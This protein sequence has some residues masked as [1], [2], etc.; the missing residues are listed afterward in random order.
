MASKISPEM[1]ELL[2]PQKTPPALLIPRWGVVTSTNPLRVQLAGDDEPLPITPKTLTGGLVLG[3]AV[4]CVLQGA[5]LIVVA[6][7]NGGDA[8]VTGTVTAST[9]TEAR[10]DGTLVCR[11][12]RSWSASTGTQ[13]FDWTFGLP[14]VG[15][16]PQIT[17]TEDTA[18]PQNVSCAYTSLALTGAT[19]WHYRST[20]VGN[21][22][23]F[24]AE[25]RWR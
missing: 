24:R 10:P 11:G 14:F 18:A 13:S 23:M 19:I 9:Y 15:E 25:G 7:L 1:L 8:L 21:V 22:S 20:A 5:D 6:Q 16:L 17:I 12:R 2:L 4:W 3:G